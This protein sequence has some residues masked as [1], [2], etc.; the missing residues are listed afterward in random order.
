MASGPP[1]KIIMYADGI[2]LTLHSPGPCSCS[3][4][5]YE[6]ASGVQGSEGH[7]DLPPDASGQD[8]GGWS[9]SDGRQDQKKG[10]LSKANN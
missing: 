10:S 9:G 8:M 5:T 1:C 3:P 4:G 2:N 7:H 6:Q